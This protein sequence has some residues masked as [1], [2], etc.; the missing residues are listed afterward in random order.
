M[1][2]QVHLE[3]AILRSHIALGPEEV[4]WVVGVDLRGA[5]I[6]A[7]DGDL[8]GQTGEGE[9]T[10]C[11]WEGLPDQADADTCGDH[12]GNDD[13]GHDGDG[14]TT[15][16]FC[17]GHPA[18]LGHI[19][20]LPAFTVSDLD[21]ALLVGT[22]VLLLSVATVRLSV[23]SGLPSLL[24]YL[25]IGMAIGEAGL[26]IHFD[27]NELTQVLGFSALVLILAEGGLTTSWDGIRRSLAPAA[28]LS[29]LGVVVSVAVVGLAAHLVL[30]VSWT[31]ALLVGAVLASTDAAAVFSVLRRV[32][33]PR[34]LTGLLE[35][36]SGFNDAPVV[37]LVLAL[38]AQ[39]SPGGGAHAPWWQLVFI[40]VAELAGGAAT[41]L[42]I[43]YAGG[44]L[45]RRIAPSSSG[46]FSIGVVSLTVLAY[47][48]GA[49]VHTSGFLAAYISALLLG[50][51]RLPHRAAVRGFAQAL[52]WLA[53][54]GLFV[55][56]GL[57]VHPA[58]LTAQIGHAVVIGLV[59][60]L[61]ARPLSV[62]LSLT[63]FRMPW[64]DQ[65]F[66]SWAGLRGGVPVVLATVPLTAGTPH[67]E[68]LFDLVFVLV[69]IFTLVQGPTLPWVAR[70]L[71]VTDTDRAIDLEVES[72]PLDELG[73]DV[74]QMTVGASSRLH[75][76][77]VFELRLPPGA[78]V[79]MVVRSGK[80]FV[81]APSTALRHGDQLLIV[82]TAETRLAAESRV[83]QISKAGRLAGWNT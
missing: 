15:G 65:V 37:I 7:Q 82:A 20:A 31:I 74:L 26:G 27:S 14:D 38:A 45:I 36:E 3:E 8:R 52:G 10:R 33:L 5:M 25:G 61:V 83:R 43:G 23:R 32:P 4:L 54:I 16:E 64:R 67:V 40:A 30:N 46:L 1:P 6:V 28:L 60:L 66:L 29:T 63:P 72:T 68:W 81:P 9:L 58:R 71:G 57:L 44:H 19:E 73:A 76:V 13:K 56:L 35:A 22:L 53:Q 17:S 47:A 34:R 2:P 75:G 24:L 48:A 70:R 77:E 18:R 39:A 62:I 42:L 59:L 49:M 80:G 11:L 21:L 79:T 12:D 50:N 51:M 55:M 69:V 78:N 41:G